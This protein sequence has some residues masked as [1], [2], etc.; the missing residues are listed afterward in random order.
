MAVRA[1]IKRAAD[2]WLPGAAYRSLFDL[3]HFLRPPCYLQ[4]TYS[5]E[6]EELIIRRFFHGRSDGFYV[7]VGAHEPRRYSNTHFLYREGWRGIDIDP[8][9]GCIARFAKERPRDTHVNVGIGAG[10]RELR[11]FMFTAWELNT[12]DTAVAARREREGHQILKIRSV[13]VRSL[14]EVLADNV[15]SGT[16]IDV[17]SVDVE[18]LDLEVLRSNDWTRFAPRLVLAEVYEKDLR[19]VMDSELAR[20]LLDYRYV[21]VAKTFNTLFFCDSQWFQGELSA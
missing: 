10:C 15:P 17:M 3:K 20:F 5:Q 16:V 14:A 9:P 8:N 19:V 18:G 6:G 13:P 11:Y 2:R 4:R 21:P 12:F 1:L 7:D